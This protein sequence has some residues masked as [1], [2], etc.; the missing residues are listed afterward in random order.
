SRIHP[1]FHI[2]LL[3]RAVGNYQVQGELPKDLE[4][5]DEN[6]I[7]PVK[8]L[9]TRTVMQGD[10]EVHQSLIQWNNK[11]ADDVTWENNEVIRGQF[12]QF[13]LEDKALLKEVGIDRNTV[14]EVGLEE[15]GPKPRVWKFYSRQRTKRNN[16]VA[17]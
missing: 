16:D 3:K 8:V 17:S 4:V 14:N 15:F 11:D 10:T 12:P 5:A 9:G 13:C 1:V 2:S 6:D 7:Y